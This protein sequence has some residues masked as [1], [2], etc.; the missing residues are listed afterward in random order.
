MKI[1]EENKQLS[2][3]ICNCFNAIVLTDNIE[4]FYELEI[5]LK[6]YVEKFIDYNEKRIKVEMKK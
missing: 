6:D 1:S 4:H 5:Y 3:L 2:V